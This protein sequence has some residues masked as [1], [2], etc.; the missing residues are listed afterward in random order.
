MDARGHR[1]ATTALESAFPDRNNTLPTSA[2]QL[3]SAPAQRPSQA[4]V[5]I[6]SSIPQ[7]P[8]KRYTPAVL[9]ED[10]Y[11]DALSTIIER[12]FFPDLKKLKTHNGYL[13]A[14]QEGDLAKARSLAVQVARM[15]TGKAPS[16][17]SGERFS[18]LTV[19][20]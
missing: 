13:A 4:M 11:I 19:I 14:V 16:V 1:I 3:G 18:Y 5:S 2:A 6:T 15:R 7:S 20:I 12:D 8:G 9:E 17:S 10:T